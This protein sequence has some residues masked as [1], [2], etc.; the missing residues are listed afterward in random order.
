MHRERQNNNYA[1]YEPRELDEKRKADMLCS[2]DM[3]KFLKEAKRM[4]AS[5]T[6]ASCRQSV[7]TFLW[8]GAFRNNAYYSQV[9]WVVQ[10]GD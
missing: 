4:Q 9:Q 3:L 6:H 8:D 5:Q 10:G 1:Q 2:E 7:A